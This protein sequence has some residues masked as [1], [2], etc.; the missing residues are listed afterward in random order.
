MEII[1]SYQG[2]LKVTVAS[3][4]NYINSNTPVIIEQ[5]VDDFK[6][7]YVTVTSIS[8]TVKLNYFDTDIK[9]LLGWN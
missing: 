7:L 1:N 9:W 4:G 5:V 8:T 3:E 2:M 6:N